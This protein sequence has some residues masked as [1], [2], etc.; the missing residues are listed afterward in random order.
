MAQNHS[1][2]YTDGEVEDLQQRTKRLLQRH[3]DRLGRNQ[4][5]TPG[6][7]PAAPSATSGKSDV[8]PSSLQDRLK[9]R[10]ARHQE[11]LSQYRSQTGGNAQW[12][13]QEAAASAYS[14]TLTSNDTKVTRSKGSGSSR[15]GAPSSASSKTGQ[16]R[17]RSTASTSPR[18]A[19]TTCAGGW[20]SSRRSR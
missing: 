3:H 4:I 20:A 8:T 5:V 13:K 9:E 18:S 19:S 16:G 12:L 14:E 15:R 2:R 6:P 17:F 1:P 7:S 11:R 10:L